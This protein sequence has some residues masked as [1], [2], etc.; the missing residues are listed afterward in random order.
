MRERR[1]AMLVVVIALVFAAY[2]GAAH[3][4]VTYVGSC[5]A[6]ADPSN[7]LTI[8]KPGS[9]SSAQMLVA[10][11]TFRLT[12]S[13]AGITPPSG[14]TLV[15]RDSSTKGDKLT[16]AVYVKAAS[17]S[18]PASYTWGFPY[19]TAAAG[20]I[21]VYSGVDNANPVLTHS[22]R[23]V[24]SSSLMT[25][26]S[27]SVSVSGALVVGLFGNSGAG[28]VSPPAGMA[29]RYESIAS[30]N[31]RATSEGADYV[32]AS[33]G[34][35]G[36]KSAQG[37][38]TSSSNIGQLVALRP[39]GS[40]G[41]GSGSPPPPTES[42][43]VN[44]SLPAIN[45][46]PQVGQTLTGTSGAWSSSSTPSYGYQWLRCNGSG[47]SCGTISG[48]TSATYGPVSSDVGSTL[49]VRVTATNSGGSTSATSLPTGLVTDAGSTGGGSGSGTVGGALPA[50]LPASTGTTFYVS[51]SG[52]DSNPGTQ[53]QPWRTITKA[54]KT[55][56]PGQRALVRAGTYAEKIEWS[57]SGTSSAPI[58]LAAYP[59]EQPVITGR[60][61]IWAFY[62]R[63]SGFEIVGQTSLNPSDVV[64]YI[65]GGRNIEISG[66]EIRNAAKS[67]VYID[68]QSQDLHFIGNWI[69]DNGTHAN[70]DHGIYW[71]EASRGLIANNLIEDNIAYGIH[72]YPDANDLVVTSNTVV[73][74][75]KSGII[76]A[77]T[78][79][80]TSDRNVLVNNIVA[81]NAEYGIRTFWNG[82]IGTG[83]SARTN[84]GYQNGSGDFATGSLAT[85]MTWSGSTSGDPAFVSRSSSNYRLGSASAALDRALS[86]YA[87][88][89]DYDGR[90]R[91]LGAAADLGAFE[92]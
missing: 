22:G 7:K 17:S 48:A 13:Y 71:S 25:A 75:G 62:V 52:S 26:P 31:Y 43:P 37:T 34:S 23:F 49:A 14:W 59:G 35:T 54:L 28:A 38:G 24:A 19:K 46:T 80:Y 53:A 33:V 27:V 10:V 3:G 86:D 30:G 85:G 60:V 63:L 8:S 15:R 47:G 79:S 82:S 1:L 12:G 21:L 55:L 56:N 87:P 70:Y 32:P 39:A 11:V 69:H 5:K 74:N 50:L 68:W 41:G 72:L 92:R 6:A 58:T 77:G 83:N 84:L 81:Y 18:E 73:E 36:D 88:R 2:V 51:T 45:G 44:T 57:R 9:A 4:A 78:G 61:K 66:N 89:T 40:S 42:A 67:G 16:Q 76:V 90:S 91:P 20:A 29:E 65:S 64:L